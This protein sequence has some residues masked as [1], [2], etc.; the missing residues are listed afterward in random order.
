MASTA[1]T[2]IDSI[3]R[4]VRDTNNTAHSRAFVRDILDRIQVTVNAHKEYILTETKI[5]A[6]PGKTIYRVETDLG[7]SITVTDVLINGRA[8]D[9][10]TWTNLHRINRHWLNADSG[11]AVAWA[12]IGRSLLAIYPAPN[13]EAEITVIASKITTPL[14][15]DEVPLELRLEDEDIVREMTTAILLFRQRD[16]DTCPSIIQRAAGKLGLQMKEVEGNE[17]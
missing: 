1:G 11:T 4:R 12:P 6:T 10:Q 5:T 7:S 13:Y 2:L 8:L 14:T 16:L 15:V 17:E 9:R 3:A